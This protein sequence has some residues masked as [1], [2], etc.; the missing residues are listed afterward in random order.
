M[1]AWEWITVVT[2]GPLGAIL[3]AWGIWLAFVNDYLYDRRERKAI[4]A[5][6]RACQGTPVIL[7]TG[8]AAR[9]RIYLGEVRWIIN[10][11]GL[12]DEHHKQRQR[13]DRLERDALDDRSDDL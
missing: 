6:C 11:I 9:S 3:I 10:P 2:L 12:C 4:R 8:D 1:N 7:L 13:I 5:S